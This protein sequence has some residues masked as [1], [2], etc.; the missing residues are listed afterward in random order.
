MEKATRQQDAVMV[1]GWLRARLRF[2]ERPISRDTL[3]GELLRHAQQT[4]GVSWK[5]GTAERRFRDARRHLVVVEHLPLVSTGRGFTL[6]PTPAER[7]RAA[8]RIER[9]IAEQAVERRVL[10]GLPEPGEPVQGFLPLT[11]AGGAR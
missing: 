9:M 5:R 4:W 10:L 3:V 2:A 8:R 11:V 6:R 1:A 7:E